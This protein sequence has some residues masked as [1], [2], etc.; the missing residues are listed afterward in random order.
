MNA[1]HIYPKSIAI[2]AETALSH[3][4]ELEDV[5]VEFK[6]KSKIR[7]S[8]MQA[9][10]TFWSV[11][12]SK[13]KRKY[14]VLISESFI[15]GDTIYDTKGMP[16]EVLI[17]WLGHELGHIMDYQHR[18][19]FNLIGFGLG[20][21]F[22]EKSMKNA[23]RRA[24]TFAVLHGMETYILATKNFILNEAG[25]SEIYKNRIKRYYLSPEEI[26]IIV[27][28]REEKATLSS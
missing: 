15:I 17:G 13:S 21:L 22:S 11:F 10:P 3:Y 5:A 2:E 16:S 4:P 18:S 12:R 23:E 8:T 28:E 7:K 9:Q 6:F 1:Q 20:Y 19:G 27:D 25:F 26:M 24:D 14:K